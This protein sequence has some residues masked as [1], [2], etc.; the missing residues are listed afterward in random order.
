MTYFYDKQKSPRIEWNGRM[1]DSEGDK[2][3]KRTP[4]S[5]TAKPHSHSKTKFPFSVKESY[6]EE[7]KRTNFLGRKEKYTHRYREVRRARILIQT[8]L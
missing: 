2:P 5:G 1:L 4:N 8:L 7:D 6:L 3:S